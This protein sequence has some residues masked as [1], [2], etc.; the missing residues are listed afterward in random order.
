MDT[1]VHLLIEAPHGGL[2]RGVQLMHGIY[3]QAFNRR[4]RRSGHLFQGR[5][6]AERVQ[7]DPQLL[8]TARYIAM[9]PVTAGMCAEPSG[10]AWSSHAAVLG[11][12]VVP[13]WFDAER[14]RGYF[15]AWG[16]D[17]R[18]RYEEFVR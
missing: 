17:G 14:I 11:D 5:Y 9:N 15:A 8:V 16:G 10:W 3:A 18:D 13:A 6:G 4:H 2:G 7:S 12:A 1:H